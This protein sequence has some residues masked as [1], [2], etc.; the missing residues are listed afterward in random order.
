MP[1]A[2]QAIGSLVQLFLAGLQRHV[3]WALRILN[4]L[5]HLLLEVRRRCFSCLDRKMTSLRGLVHAWMPWL[6]AIM[7]LVVDSTA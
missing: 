4:R 2:A 3:S 7:L 5:L 1:T 6:R